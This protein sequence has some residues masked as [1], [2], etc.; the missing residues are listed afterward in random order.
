MFKKRNKLGQTKNG[1]VHYNQYC[2]WFTDF[3]FKSWEIDK[4]VDR[5]Y[6]SEGKKRKQNTLKLNEVYLVNMI[7]MCYE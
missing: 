3:G 1:N 7:K 6:L 2:N 4:K 5:S